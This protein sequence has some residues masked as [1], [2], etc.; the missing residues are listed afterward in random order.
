MNGTWI[1]VDQTSADQKA[2]DAFENT[3]AQVHKQHQREHEEPMSLEEMV[4]KF[5]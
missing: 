4:M 2:A 1:V 3:I 5:Y